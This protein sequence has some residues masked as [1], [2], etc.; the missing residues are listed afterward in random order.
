MT[1]VGAPLGGV[2][3]ALVGPGEAILVDATTF[4]VSVLF[5]SRLRLPALA[6]EEAEPETTLQAI[7][8]GW[9]E[10]RARPWLSRFLGILF[11]YSFLVLPCVFVL[12]PLI[13]ERDLGGA[14]A[15]GVISGGFAV[16]AIGGGIVAMRWRPA[17]RM[18]AVALM[19]A[20]ASTQ[21]ALYAIFDS[22]AALTLAFAVAG[23]AVGAA[24]AMWEGTIQQ[25]VPEHVLSRVIAYDFT[26]SAGSL[27]IGMALAG[28]V[29]AAAGVEATLLAASAVCIALAMTYALRGSGNRSLT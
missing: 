26:V 24:W 5:L 25:R 1:L 21:A 9:R 16:G 29:A 2:L 8:A 14:G 3:V 20:G 27:P 7:A 28:P 12:G 13:A 18:R 6:R 17:H 19:F 4:V 15:Y 23:V 10:V 11:A 22:V